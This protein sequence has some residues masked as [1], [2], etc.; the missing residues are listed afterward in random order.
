MKPRNI[1]N[2]ISCIN[3]YS[4]F[5]TYSLFNSMVYIFGDVRNISLKSFKQ[6]LGSSFRA[7]IKF[8]KYKNVCLLFARYEFE[9]E[10]NKKVLYSEVYETSLNTHLK[11]VCS[12]QCYLLLIFCAL[13]RPIYQAICYICYFTLIYGKRSCVSWKVLDLEPQQQ[14]GLVSDFCASLSNLFLRQNIPLVSDSFTYFTL[15]DF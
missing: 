13:G 10:V 6:K 15:A 5:L 2:A 4:Y 9:C 1:C 11:M 8:G 12:L 7:S 3:I 14:L